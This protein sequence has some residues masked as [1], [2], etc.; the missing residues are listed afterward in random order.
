M[1]LL[2]SIFEPVGRPGYALA[3]RGLDADLRH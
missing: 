2:S 1:A 3:Y